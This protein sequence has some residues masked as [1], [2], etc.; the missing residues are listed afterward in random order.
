MTPFFRF[1]FVFVIFSVSACDAVFTPTPLGDDVVA[2]DATEWQGTWLAPDMVITTTVLDKDTGLL[3]VA[4][5]ERGAK[6]A[7]LELL[8]G[9]I[10]ASGELVFA[11]VPDTNPNVEPRYL[12]LMIDKAENRIT[13]WSQNLEQFKIAVKNADLPVSTDVNHSSNRVVAL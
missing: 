11:N 12:W 9:S 6:G 4:W 3:Q 13:V 2:L 5:V 8:E 1:L 10:R 7:S